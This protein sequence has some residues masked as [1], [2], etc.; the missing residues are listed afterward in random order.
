MSVAK[1]RYVDVRVCGVL[2]D[3]TIEAHIKQPVSPDEAKRIGD[4][5][6]LVADGKLGTPT[7]AKP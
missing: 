1:I 6:P 3:V 2:C 4:A 5:L 7:E